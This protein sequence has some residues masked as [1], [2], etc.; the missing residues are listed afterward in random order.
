VLKKIIQSNV[1][2]NQVFK[3]IPIILKFKQ[4]KYTASWWQMA[5][6]SGRLRNSSKKRW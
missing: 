3:A 1:E 5:A 6:R 2:R 4:C